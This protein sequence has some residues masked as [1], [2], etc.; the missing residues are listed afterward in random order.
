MQMIW[1]ALSPIS[2]KIRWNNPLLET[3]HGWQYTAT[4]PNFGGKI[5]GVDPG[6]NLGITLID[7]ENV[8]IF[9]GKLKTLREQRIGYSVMAHDLLVNLIDEYKMSKATFVLEGAAFNKTF[10]QV[11]L[12]EVRTGYYIAMKHYSE[13]I[14]IP[15]PMS[16][17]KKVCGDGRVQPGDLWPNVNHN[18]CD[19]LSIALYA[20]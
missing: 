10:G 15:A 18:A 1:Q 5:V 3:G 11:Q 8:R 16:V 17:R 6:V 13:E 7:H 12:A 14:A 9:H 4:L 19:S 2:E 20:V